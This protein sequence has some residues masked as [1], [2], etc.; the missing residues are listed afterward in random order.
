M[1]ESPESQTVPAGSP[2]TFTA[3]YTGLPEP[4]ATWLVGG[5]PVTVG[6]N[7]I[8]KTTEKGNVNE[9]LIS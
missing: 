8:M 1:I 3:R 6:E 7:V 4:T 9:I 2:V 5:E